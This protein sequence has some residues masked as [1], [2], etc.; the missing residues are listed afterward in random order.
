MAKDLFLQPHLSPTVEKLKSTGKALRPNF[1]SAARSRT[2]L[3][4]GM[5][6]LR[7]VGVDAQVTARRDLPD[8][9]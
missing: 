7:A 9:P 6:T 5:E 3:K 1:M 4:T 8:H 2:S